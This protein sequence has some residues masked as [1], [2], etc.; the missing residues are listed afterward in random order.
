MTYLENFFTTVIHLNIYLIILISIVYIVIHQHR[1]KK[2]QSILDVYL[3][4]IPV[5]THEFGHVLFNRLAGG[6]AK[7]LVI[8]TSPKERQST[9][10]QGYAITQSRSYLGQFITTI[11]GYLMPPI[12]FLIGLVA[13]HYQHPSIF[14]V[15]YL[16]IFIYFLILT[17]RKLS[18]IIVILL[19][20]ILLYF[21]F[22][23]DNQMIM[24]DI[25][26]LSYHFILGVLLGK[27]FN[28]H[29]RYLT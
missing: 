4:Y 25:V 27:F 24:Y 7:D 12:M 17:S 2:Y 18:P 29:G 19:I 28:P 16:F 26:S 8:V 22:K 11:G 15:S 21:L 3:N 13:A 20:G 5:L 6:R 9:L 10:Q 23:H 1:H 14:L